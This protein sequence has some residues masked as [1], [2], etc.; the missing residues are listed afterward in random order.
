[1]GPYFKK[2]TES[3]F[4]SELTSRS[5]FSVVVREVGRPAINAELARLATKVAFYYHELGMSQQDI[6][7]SLSLSQ[8]RISRLLSYANSNGIIKTVIDVPA[9]V[10]LELERKLEEAYGLLDVV[11]FDDQHKSNPNSSLAHE[12]AIFL[13]ATL[14]SDDIVGISSWSAT[15][16]EAAEAMTVRP[17]KVVQK[18]V[19]LIGGTGNRDA[20]VH[21][22]RLVSRF[23]EVVSADPIFLDAPGVV[24][25]SVD[26]AKF[27]SETTRVTGLWDELTCALTGIG[28]IPQSK[29]LQASGHSLDSKSLEEVLANGAVG[30]VCLRFFDA[31]GNPVNSTFDD[32]VFSIGANQLKKVPRRIGIASG[33]HKIS[34]I[35]GA[36]QGKWINILITDLSTAEK[37]LP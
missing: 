14:S 34:A 11:I 37:L 28:P 27:Q 18:V 24:A 8:A 29:L 3:R 31:W 30:E 26:L 15:L 10:Q 7:K 2:S 1:M 13:E 22:G 9:G 36:I 16:L 23:A 6:G 5:L 25:S 20:Q 12:S 32:T 19:H 21:A 17:H 35:K 33:D 4:I